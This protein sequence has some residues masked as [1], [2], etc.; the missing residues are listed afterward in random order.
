MRTKFA[1]EET[2]IAAYENWK[3]NW[4]PPV[5]RPI[6][7]RGMVLV[8]FAPSSNS[9][10][11]FMPEEESNNAMVICDGYEGI[12]NRYGHLQPGTEICYTGV[13][14]EIFEYQGR[15]I[16]RLKKQDIE[17]VCTD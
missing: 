17:M 4:K 7:M 6:A 8:E 12:P 13:E 9:G 10:T 14:G 16:T 2:P 15:K 1:T 3:K 5:P 11:I